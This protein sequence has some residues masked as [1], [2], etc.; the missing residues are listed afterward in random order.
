MRK[1]LVVVLFALLFLAVGFSAGYEGGT[2]LISVDALSEGAKLLFGG[3]VN[4]IVLAVILVVFAL[5][6]WLVRQL[7]E[8]NK[9]DSAGMVAVIGM[10][11][12]G[13]IGLGFIDLDGRVWPFVVF[14]LAIAIET[15]LVMDTDV[16]PWL[17]SIRDRFN[18]R[19]DDWAVGDTE[20]I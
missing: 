2:T 5:I 6:G 10:I 3:V 15:L 4:L 13:I 8:S 9:N 18:R 17:A 7:A 11:V 20:E 1:F 12:A 16:R 14:L 19:R